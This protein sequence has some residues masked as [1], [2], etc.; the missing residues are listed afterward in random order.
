MNEKQQH[1]R[2]TEHPHPRSAELCTPLWRNPSL[3]SKPCALLTFSRWRFIHRV[4]VRFCTFSLST[5]NK[6]VPLAGCKEIHAKSHPP[7]PKGRV[8]RISVGWGAPEVPYRDGDLPRRRLARAWG[9]PRIH[10]LQPNPEH[11]K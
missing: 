10:F 2:N 5:E 8:Y 11:L 6:E 7:L 9:A 4:K 3:N 1:N